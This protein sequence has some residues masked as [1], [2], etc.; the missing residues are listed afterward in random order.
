MREK[1]QMRVESYQVRQKFVHFSTSNLLFFG[2]RALCEIRILFMTETCDLLGAAYGYE[3]HRI[4][5]N[6]NA[7]SS[8]R[9]LVFAWSYPG[10]P[11]E[12]TD[13]D[14]R[15]IFNVKGTERKTIVRDKLSFSLRIP[16]G[17]NLRVSDHNW[18]QVKS[19]ISQVSAHTYTS[20]K[21]N[22]LQS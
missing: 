20:K 13:C 14:C 8:K 7:A 16:V 19:S 3:Q 21:Y 10:A 11:N 5:L 17:R 18:L 1:I 15:W 12:I 4:A 6:T 22:V 9:N 2:A